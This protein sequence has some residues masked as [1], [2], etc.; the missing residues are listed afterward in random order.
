MNSE[1]RRALRPHWCWRPGAQWWAMPCGSVTTWIPERTPSSINNTQ[2]SLE[3]WGKLRSW[4][5][6]VRSAQSGCGTGTYPADFAS[7][8]IPYKMPRTLNPLLQHLCLASLALFLPFLCCSDPAHISAPLCSAQCLSVPEELG[9]QEQAGLCS[10]PCTAVTEVMFGE[11][12]GERAEYLGQKQPS[13]PA[14]C[15]CHLILCIWYQPEVAKGAVP[16]AVDGK[17]RFVKLER[18]WAVCSQRG[19]CIW[20]CEAGRSTC[21]ADVQCSE[22]EMWV[23][24]IEE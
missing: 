12:Q 8:K 2:K 9:R 11:G 3:F 13:G 21:Q 5:R 18:A 17:G 6:R 24:N 7:Y 1:G 19:E 10:Q 20:E 4:G 22:R 23:K 14:Q 16:M 15:W